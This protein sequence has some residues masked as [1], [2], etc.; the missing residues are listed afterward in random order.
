MKVQMYL[1]SGPC[2]YVQSYHPLRLGRRSAYTVGV[3]VEHG[4][5]DHGGEDKQEADGDKQIHGCDVGN[6]GQRIT[7]YGAQCGHGQNCG[8]SCGD[9]R[10]DRSENPSRS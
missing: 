7:G 8:D 9:R 1:N 10:K 3:V 4:V 5:L 6:S 2:V